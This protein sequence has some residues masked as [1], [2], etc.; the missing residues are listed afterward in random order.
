MRFGF[1]HRICTFFAIIIDFARFGKYGEWVENDNFKELTDVRVICIPHYNRIS[2]VEDA[3]Q[4]KRVTQNTHGL[5]SSDA[6]I[7]IY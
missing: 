7:N 1:G 5:L 6:L 3:S 2:K 4:V